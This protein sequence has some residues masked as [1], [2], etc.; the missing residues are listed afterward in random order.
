VH[1]TLEHIAAEAGATVVY[2]NLN[3]PI[4]SQDQVVQAFE[5]TLLSLRQKRIRY[6]IIDHI[7]SKPSFI[8]P[9]ERLVRLCHSHKILTIVD[10]AHAPGQVNFCS[11]GHEEGKPF[12]LTSL[13]ADFYIGQC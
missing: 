2:V 5:A 11:P 7:S 8:L 12:S 4:T 10:G 3:L 9:I 13:G 1:D 6:A